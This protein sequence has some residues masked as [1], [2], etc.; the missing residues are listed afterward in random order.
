MRLGLIA[1]LHGDL[2]GFQQALRLFER[3]SVERIL[4]AGDVVERGSGADTI[5]GMI[6]QQ[7]IPCIR[8][9]HD[10]TIVANQ[11]HWRDS[12][13]PTRLV[14][15]GRI[16]SDSTL[17][18]LKNLPETLTFLFDSIRLLLA[19]G[20]PW[21]DV[22]TV[23]PDTRQGVLDRIVERHSASTDVI[24]LGH[25]HQPMRLRIAG[26]WI[27]NPG[28]VYGVTIRDSHTCAI[29]DIPSCDLTVLDL[30]TGSPLAV[31]LVER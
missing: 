11:A 7:G 14:E 10:A 8:G 25:T 9:N 20:T 22:M 16:V 27:V 30:K 26:L 13:N 19:H 28:S 6:Q 29:L 3:E 17:H 1:D 21:S 31:P 5:I 15:L 18:F 4:C 24:I 2:E 23:F 12:D